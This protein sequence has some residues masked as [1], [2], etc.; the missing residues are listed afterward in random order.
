MICSFNVIR[1]LSCPKYISLRLFEE[2]IFFILFEIWMECRHCT[3]LLFNDIFI[4]AESGM[5]ILNSN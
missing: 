4:V 2:L 5:S 1:V 3:T